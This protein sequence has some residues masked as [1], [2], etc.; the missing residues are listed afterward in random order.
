[1]VSVAQLVE[2]R[3]VATIIT[4]PVVCFQS[5]TT[6]SFGAIRVIW[7]GLEADWVRNGYTQALQIGGLE[8][9]EIKA[10]NLEPR[11]GF[12]LTRPTENA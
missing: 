8:L 2:H 10:E 7:W 1:M 12:E 9:K 6:Q 3:S 4:I 5:V 11:V